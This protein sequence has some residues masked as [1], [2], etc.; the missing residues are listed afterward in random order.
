MQLNQRLHIA[1]GRSMWA[2]V[3]VGIGVMGG[4]DE[5]VFHQILGWHHFYDLSTPTIGLVS[6]GLLHAV[7]LLAIVGGFFLLL[8]LRQ[9][10]ALKVTSAWSG[11]FL[12]AGGFQLFD[13]LITH[14]VLRLHQIRY[15]V[16]LLPYDLLW[17][18]S[19]VVLIFFGL[20]LLRRARF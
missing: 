3:L 4:I 2:A 17:N 5:I 12:G 19:A 20:I 18:L 11:F 8:D 6:D 16:P 14:K 1:P 13:G 7:E 15:D 10:H 9:S